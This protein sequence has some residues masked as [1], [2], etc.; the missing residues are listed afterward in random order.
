L[1]LHDERYV[2]E[3]QVRRT[4]RGACIKVVTDRPDELDQIRDRVVRTLR[5]AGLRDPEVT[6]HAVD[7]LERLASG[8]LRQFIPRLGA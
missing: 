6:V 2:A 1:E 7:R 3:Y 5:I 4:T 8:K